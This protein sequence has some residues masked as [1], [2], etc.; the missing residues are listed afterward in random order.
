[1]E[2]MMMLLGQ[3][4]MA[5]AE[6]GRTLSVA[7]NTY[8]RVLDFYVNQAHSKVDIK[9]VKK[10]LVDE[11][12]I[13]KGHD[14]VTVICEPSQPE[15]EKPTRVLFVTEGN[16]HKTLEATAEFLKDHGGEADQIQMVCSDMSSAFKKGFNQYFPKAIQVTDYFHV[17]L[18]STI[19]SVWRQLKFPDWGMGSDTVFLCCLLMVRH[20][21]W[22]SVGER[23]SDS[24]S[25]YRNG[26]EGNVPILFGRFC[27][28]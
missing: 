20:C 10:L 24:D 11:T 26:A 14:Y 27:F 9:E 8:W 6:A 23:W 1:M 22:R 13:R 19:S 18:A 3:S 7:D 28:V 5:V 2:A 25:A 15:K 16:E 21:L 4:G 12:S 17:C